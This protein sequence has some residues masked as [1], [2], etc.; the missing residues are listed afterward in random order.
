MTNA[1]FRVKNGLYV[2]ED[3]SSSGNLT[4]LDGEID[5]DASITLDAANDIVLDAHGEDIFLKKA[6]VT[7]GSLT[8]SSGN[9][10]VVK[11]GTT[12]AMTFVGANA[13]LGGT[14]TL[15]GDI[16]G[17]ANLDTVIAPQDGNYFDVD[18]VFKV[19]PAVATSVSATFTTSGGTA[20]SHTTLT[21]TTGTPFTDFP[22]SGYVKIAGMTTGEQPYA[23]TRTSATVLVS[24]AGTFDSFTATTK[25]ITLSPP[26]IDIDGQA[27][28]VGQ[29][30]Q[31][32]HDGGQVTLDGGKWGQAAGGAGANFAIGTMYGSVVLQDSISAKKLTADDT[33]SGAVYKLNI[34][35]GPNNT[36]PIFHIGGSNQDMTAQEDYFTAYGKSYLASVQSSPNETVY[37]NA[38][39]VADSLAMFKVKSKVA[40]VPE[41]D[42][43]SRVGTAIV[44]ESA[45]VSAMNGLYF[46]VDDT[47][48]SR[49]QDSGS[50]SIGATD[51]NFA[52]GHIYNGL[53]STS[54]VL[55]MGYANRTFNDG[56]DLNSGPFHTGSA[57]Y[58]AQGNALA[59]ENTFFQASITGGVAVGP[60]QTPTA[61]VTLTVGKSGETNVG[62]VIRIVQDSAAPSTTTDRLYNDDG[63]LM[64][65]TTNLSASS[66]SDIGDLGDVTFNSGNLVIDA[67][68]LVSPSATAHN[69][70]GT[71]LVVQGGSTT[72]ATTNNIAGGSLTLAGGQGKGTGAGGDIIFQVA[73]QSTTGSSLNSLAE[74]ARIADD[75]NVGIGDAAPGT[76]LQLSAANAYLTLKNTTAENGAGGAET[77]IIFEDHGNNALG[78]I[79]VSHVS[80]ADDEKGQM[81][82]ST[83]NDSGLQAALT[84]SDA[85]LATFAGDVTISGN[86]LTF[87]NG[88]TI[89]NTSTSV[90]TITEAQTNFSGDIQVGGNDIKA[91]DGTTALTLSGANVTVAGNLTVSGTT[92][93]VNTT[94]MTVEDALIE[95]GIVDGAAPTSDTS[96]DS[97]MLVNYYSSSAAKKAGFYWD[98]STTA[99]SLSEVVAEGGSQVLTPT[100]GATEMRY[101]YD[102]TNY[103]SIA[104]AANGATTLATVDSDGTAAHLTLD[105]GGDIILDAD[106]ANITFK[107]NGTTIADFLLSSTN[108]TLDSVGDITL[109]VADGKDIILHEAG[110][111]YA[112]IG[113]GSVDIA[114]I[115]EAL[116]TTIDTFDCTSYQAT[117]YL[118][119]VEDTTNTNYLSTEILVLGDENGV[120]TA[121]GYLTQYAVLYNNTELGDFSVTGSSNNI[122]LQYTAGDMSGASQHKV[123]VV[124]QRIASI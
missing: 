60:A 24:T 104:V 68:D 81:I 67:L 98:S 99:W 72:A 19:T 9:D 31:F 92:I 13:T 25:Q 76:L 7:W 2:V 97:G 114:N 112:S 17:T 65:G 107:D 5:S 42:A 115:G 118:I 106:G 33:Q 21:A 124:A 35:S 20:G 75:G 8:K 55:A 109:D 96:W 117:K 28:P 110:S 57:T 62:G 101:L 50:G 63:A 91:S 71:A 48:F 87:G 120:S 12:T 15:G 108:V 23:F 89:V 111:I 27:A 10:L 79:E 83:N 6:T 56:T 77:K 74:V 94:N 29:T 82:F 69:A 85:Q 14:L 41:T 53:T 46:N 80:T 16:T 61:S 73:N 38:K 52:V 34:H 93:A 54:Q 45:A 30:G 123:R 49:W 119:L 66:A 47:N 1:N 32:A 22:Q 3:Q 43:D 113:Q 18:G 64:W 95:L 4:L 86:D 105:A 88:A 11:S 102:A 122:S 78:Q 58:G 116:A 90:L 40:N 39:V 70:A 44:S 100:A 36:V 121:V 37:Y 59:S 103:H 51:Y 26:A 84:L